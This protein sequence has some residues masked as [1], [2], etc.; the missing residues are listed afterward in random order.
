M[1]RLFA[2]SFQSIFLCTG[3]LPEICMKLSLPA[4]ATRYTGGG[5]EGQSVVLSS[6]V[7]LSES[8]SW[9]VIAN[10]IAVVI[11]K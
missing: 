9:V 7:K 6:Y 3:N 2:L 11:R 8:Q 4:A 1:Y 10:F 5:R